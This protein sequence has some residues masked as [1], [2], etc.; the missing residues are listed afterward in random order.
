MSYNVECKYCGKDFVTKD[1]RNLF[2][3]ISCGCKNRKNLILRQCKYCGDVFV[4]NILHTR[5]FCN[6]KCKFYKNNTRI[7]EY[8][9]K[10]FILDNIAYE[11]R[12]GGRYCGM[13]CSTLANKKHTFDENYFTHIDSSEKAYWLGF[14]FADGYNT[15]DEIVIELAEKDITHLVKFKKAISATQL[16]STRSKYDKNQ[17]NTKEFASIR[18]SSRR[19]CKTLSMHGMI[20]NKAHT[21]KYPDISPE[22]DRH[23]IRGFFDGDGC[24]FT[25]RVGSKCKMRG[26]FSI[27]SH[28]EEFIISLINRLLMSGIE[29]KHYPNNIKISKKMILLKIFNYLYLDTTENVRM[30]RKYL[31]FKELVDDIN[32]HN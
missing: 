32:K 28:S 2:C 29:T 24:I 4:C 12:G 11:K 10:S 6:E 3:S 22:H 30:D 15:D 9:E 8:C 21:L 19:I 17:R 26:D 1:K 5:D 18:I 14:L 27:Y 31:K 25:K 7:C 23:F 20:R 13:T 16:I